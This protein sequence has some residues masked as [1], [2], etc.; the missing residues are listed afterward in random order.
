MLAEA[1]VQNTLKKLRNSFAFPS[2]NQRA[3]QMS[4]TGHRFDDSLL[5]NALW[6]AFAHTVTPR[7]ARH[8]DLCR[9]ALI[10]YSL[11]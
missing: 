11:V 3:L 7:Q 2:L 9:L 10:W 4:V 8:D 6:A 1:H 5:N